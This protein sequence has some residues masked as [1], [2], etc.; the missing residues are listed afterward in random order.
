MPL[1]KKKDTN[2]YLL[3]NYKV[4]YSTIHNQDNLS[5]VR[6]NSSLKLDILLNRFFFSS[7]KFYF[8]SRNPY[9]RIESFFK[10][11]FRNAVDY[12]ERNGYWQHSQILFFKYLGIDENM[13]P[14]MIKQRLISTSFK[15]IVMILPKVYKDDKHLHPQWFIKIVNIKKYRVPIK[16]VK[17]FKM[18]SQDDLQELQ[19]IFGIDITS[20]VNSTKEVF[21]E[22]VWSDDE[23]KIIELLYSKDFKIFKYKKKLK[24]D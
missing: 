21:D 16:L 10:D 19:S 18:E 7:S 3:T 5:L 23:L 6:M 22:L 20:K 14:E 17:V 24:I 11:K 2:K 15:E 1:F 12:Y 13:S 9:E 4:M 8:I